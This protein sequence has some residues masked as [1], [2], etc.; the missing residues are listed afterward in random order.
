MKGEIRL[1]GRLAQ[2]EQPLELEKRFLNERFLSR[3]AARRRQP[4]AFDLDAHAHFKH[5]DRLADLA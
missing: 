1:A 3:V 5:V 4:R 2:V